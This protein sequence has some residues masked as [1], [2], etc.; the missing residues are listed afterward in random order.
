MLRMKVCLP[1]FFF[2][3]PSDACLE[4]RVDI[5]PTARWPE[6]KGP[7]KGGRKGRKRGRKNKVA[8]RKS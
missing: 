6:G 1:S 5:P 2:C 4:R 3:T 7:K 8:I